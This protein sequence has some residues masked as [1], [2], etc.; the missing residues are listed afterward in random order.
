MVCNSVTVVGRG[1]ESKP[2][3]D[4]GCGANEWEVRMGGGVMKRKQS[5]F[6]TNSTRATVHYCGD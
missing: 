4:T 2:E 5:N 1:G 6:E 3:G